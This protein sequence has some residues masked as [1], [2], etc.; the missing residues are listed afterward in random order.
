MPAEEMP[1]SKRVRFS[2]S[3]RIR[4]TRLVPRLE[5]SNWH[6]VSRAKWL[7]AWCPRACRRNSSLRHLRYNRIA[8]CLADTH[9]GT[10]AAE[11]AAHPLFDFLVRKIDGGGADVLRHRTRRT[12]FELLNPSDG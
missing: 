3:S 6:G 9:I 12:V 11:I 10:A 7:L 1:T 8:N 2:T 4:S 5:T